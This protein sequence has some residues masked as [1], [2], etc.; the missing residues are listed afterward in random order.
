[1]MMAA[2]LSVARVAWPPLLSACVVQQRMRAAP[3]PH[4]QQQRGRCNLASCRRIATLFI[5]YIPSET[6]PCNKGL[7]ISTASKARYIYQTYMLIY[8]IKRNELFIYRLLHALC[9]PPPSEGSTFFGDAGSNS[10]EQKDRR[11]PNPAA[12]KHRIITL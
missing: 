7:V 2:A 12:R 6:C 10:F 1:M 3:V 8:N 11:G 9:V 4:A 5:A